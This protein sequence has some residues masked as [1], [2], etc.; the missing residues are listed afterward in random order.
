[1]TS[2]FAFAPAAPSARVL[3]VSVSARS[4]TNESPSLSTLPF[5]K[6]QNMKMSSLSGENES[7]ID[8][9]APL[10]LALELP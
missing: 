10:S 6:A 7:L 4:A 5:S 2:A 1:M 9:V 3:S 8:R